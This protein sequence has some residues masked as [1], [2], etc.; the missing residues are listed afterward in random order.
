MGITLWKFQKELFPVNGR[1]SPKEISGFKYL[2]KGAHRFYALGGK[3]PAIFCK[4]P[5]AA[6]VLKV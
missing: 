6:L 3:R 1:K 2:L 5:K 4:E